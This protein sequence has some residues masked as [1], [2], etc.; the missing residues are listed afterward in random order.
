MQSNDHEK[1]HVFLLVGVLRKT[2]RYG[3]GNKLRGN[4]L[5]RFHLE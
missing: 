1:V 3:T 2:V 5:K 4:I